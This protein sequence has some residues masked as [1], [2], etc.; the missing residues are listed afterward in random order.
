MPSVPRWNIGSVSFLNARPL[1]YGLDAHP[2]V[3]LVRDAP[4]RLAERMEAEELDA[5]LLPTIDY[6]RLTA[7]AQER[8]RHRPLVILPGASIASRGAVDSVRLFCRTDL[9]L[10]R[11]VALDPNSHTSNCLVR[12]VVKARCSR[13]PHFRWPHPDPLS[14]DTES[15]AVL[16]IGNR[17]L[18]ED[19]SEYYQTI[20]LGEAWDRLVGLPLVYAMWTARETDDL[21]QLSAILAEAKARGLAA[22]GELAERG[23]RE[24]GITPEVAE[25]YLRERIHYDLGPDELAGLQHFYRWSAQEELAPLHIPIR[26]VA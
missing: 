1:D 16:L 11:H 25:R 10:A 5:A 6:F 3:R 22:R 24:L 19:E 2:D 9:D 18:V 7:D 21:D 26:M 8:H 23:A 4:S 17:A 20:D 13:T 12:L 15:D 14:P